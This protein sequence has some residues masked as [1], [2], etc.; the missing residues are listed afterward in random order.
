MQQAPAR[1]DGGPAVA[2]GGETDHH[3]EAVLAAPRLDTLDALLPVS[4]LNIKA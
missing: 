1:P 4:D 2:V 3:M